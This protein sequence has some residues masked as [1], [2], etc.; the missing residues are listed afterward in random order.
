MDTNILFPLLVA[1]GYLVGSVPFGLVL[2]RMAGY[3]DIRK[4]GSGNIGATNVLR[5]GNKPLAAL[6]LFLDSGKGAIAVIVIHVLF[7]INAALLAG[8][9]AVLG[10]IFPVW[11]KFR[12]GKGVATTLG[13]LIAAVPLSGLTACAIWLGMACMFRISSLAAL[14]AM[15]FVP[16]MTLVFYG[17]FPAAVT[18]VIAAVVWVRHKEN[19]IRLLRGEEPKIGKR[20]NEEQQPAGVK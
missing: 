13:T 18:F 11:L 12:G 17:P 10:H 4:T 6:T 16:V 9:A 1:A 3:G 19:I 5:T 15:A 7:G 8:L 14:T 2:C 20:K